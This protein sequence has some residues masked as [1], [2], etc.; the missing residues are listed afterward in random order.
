[1]K[2][3]RILL[4]KILDPESWVWALSLLFE[5]CHL[6]Q[7]TQFYCFCFLI[8]KLVVC[9]HAHAQLC[10]TLC[11]PMDYSPPDSP[12]HGIFQARIVEQV[13]ISSSRASSQHRDWTCVSCVSCIGRQ[14][15]NHCATWQGCYSSCGFL[16]ERNQ[17]VR[18]ARGQGG[19]Q[20]QWLYSTNGRLRSREGKK[21]SNL[22]SE[23]LME[24]K[25]LQE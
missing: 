22:L 17:N 15:L 1:M 23:F 3:S 16:R 6:S 7:I 12:I 5:L 18:A 24:L 10:P 8:Y 4:R 9:V 14:I 20:V 13:A 11:D 19:H 2:V 21:F 25:L